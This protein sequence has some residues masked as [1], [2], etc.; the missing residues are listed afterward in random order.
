[1][2]HPEKIAKAWL[3]TGLGQVVAL[4]AETAAAAVSSP[5]L[6][7]SSG[8]PVVMMHGMGDFANNPMGMVPL[9]KL[10]AKEAGAY[11]ASVALCSEK[12]RLA[13]CDGEDQQNGFRMVMD[14][15]V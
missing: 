13:G 7:A 11:V 14:D 3:K 2:F 4:D 6:R 8:T 1:M 15:E 12:A 10:I 5:A 9:K